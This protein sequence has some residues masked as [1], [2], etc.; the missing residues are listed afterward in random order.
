[1]VRCDFHPLYRPRSIARRPSRQ[2]LGLRLFA[3]PWDREG[4]FLIGPGE[5]LA[6][7][8]NDP[9]LA[10][11]FQD[12]G[13]GGGPGVYKME[14]KNVGDT[15]RT[16]GDLS[17]WM[18]VRAE[19]L[20][21]DK[22]E[23]KNG[24]STGGQTMMGRGSC[25]FNLTLINRMECS[26]TKRDLKP[27]PLFAMGKCSVSWHADSCLEDFSTIGTAYV[28]AAA[29]RTKYCDLIGAIVEICGFGVAGD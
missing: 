28:H 8:L 17:D 27:D 14:P 9:C 20:L 19:A 5:G 24:C 22:D 6:D 1:M 12:D 15:L 4:N 11:L 10:E 25:T 29:V 2:Y 26:A 16:V 7:A 18:R 13:V 23:G 21:H 3:H